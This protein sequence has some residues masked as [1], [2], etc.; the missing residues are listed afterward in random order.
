[1]ST[2]LGNP[3][4]DSIKV[5]I[6]TKL[7]GGV[8]RGTET[9]AYELKHRLPFSTT[10]LSLTASDWTV[11]VPGI[12]R[13]RSVHMAY[14]WLFDKFKLKWLDSLMPR[15]SCLISRYSI[16]EWS[17]GRSAVEALSAL[18]PDVVLNQSGPIVGRYCAAYRKR[19]GVPFVVAGG[20]GVGR[21]ER[22]NVYTKPD[23]YIAKNPEA[24]RF[25]QA[26][27]PEMDAVLVPNGVN[28]DMFTPDGTRLSPD[29]LR[30]LSGNPNLVVERPAVISTSAL[31]KGKRLHLVI[32]AMRILGRG[33][34]LL[35]G[36]GQ[37]KDEIVA[38]GRRL[39]GSRFGYL[40]AFKYPQIAPL[41]RSGD[42]FCMPSASEAFGNAA[43]EAM[44]CGIPVVTTDDESRRWILGAGGGI[45]VDPTDVDLL[46]AAIEQASERDWGDG[47]PRESLRFDWVAIA[48]T[49]ARILDEVSRRP[50][51]AERHNSLSVRTRAR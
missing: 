33:T 2:P 42:V 11:Q 14:S 35:A 12:T 1:M 16:E 30:G 6:L 19:T 29:E 10:V 7:A 39:L 23:K 28:L 27:D 41:Y 40:G 17:Y 36:C 48:D 46:A 25:V 49:Y 20:A 44:A 13:E 21:A 50:K 34:L 32:E 22:K 24:L 5:A 38:L 31:E 15:C 47:P 3:V 43:V 37:M 26:I 8:C 18:K 9:I 45:V 4:S 51:P